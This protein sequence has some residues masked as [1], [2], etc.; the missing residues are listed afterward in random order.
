M[1]YK[2]SHP[3]ALPQKNAKRIPQAQRLFESFLSAAQPGSRNL[4]RP[5]KMKRKY[6]L[7]KTGC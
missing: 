3:A 4:S 6:V 5:A 2:T 7:I 1:H